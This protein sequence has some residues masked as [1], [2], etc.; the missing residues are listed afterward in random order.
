M[1]RSPR[2]LHRS[3]RTSLLLNTVVVTVAAR[4]VSAHPR[5]ALPRA[6]SL[7]LRTRGTAGRGGGGGGGGGFGGG[8]GGR[9]GG[10]GGGR[11]RP[12]PFPLF[13]LCLLI[14]ALFSFSLHLYRDR[15]MLP[16]LLPRCCHAGCQCQFYL[17]GCLVFALSGRSISLVLVLFRKWLCVFL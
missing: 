14:R 7:S 10:W 11:A 15:A 17:A 3:N 1:T 6:R 4:R 5:R 16:A 13:S 12:A 9:G 8:G 2:H